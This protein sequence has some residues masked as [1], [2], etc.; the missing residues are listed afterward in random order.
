[1]KTLEQI[2]AWKAAGKGPVE[3]T[4][5]DGSTLYFSTPTR[6]QFRLI[7]AKMRTGGAV[8]ITEAYIKNCHLGGDLTIE[9]ILDDNDS[10]YAAEI[11]AT[12][13]ELLN[14]KAAAVKKL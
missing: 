6:K 1:M 12:I 5:S 13:D 11:G 7:M 14:T 8:G 2:K 3:V 9:Q 10:T 4:L